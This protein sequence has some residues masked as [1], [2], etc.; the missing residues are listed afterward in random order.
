MEGDYSSKYESLLKETIFG[1]R[2]RA[3]VFGYNSERVENY[4]D[5]Q[6]QLLWAIEDTAQMEGIDVRNQNSER[7]GSRLFDLECLVVESRF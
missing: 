3:F 1:T 7:L 6:K 4:L 2:V 5:K